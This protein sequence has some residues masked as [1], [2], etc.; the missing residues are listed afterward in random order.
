[1]TSADFEEQEKYEELERKWSFVAQKKGFVCERCQKDIE[2][3]ERDVY[4]LTDYC[5][6][7]AHKVEKGE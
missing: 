3:N 2:Y 5:G 4:F 1:M 6:Y 7:C